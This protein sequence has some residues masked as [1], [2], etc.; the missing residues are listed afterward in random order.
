[1]KKILLILI[2]GWNML[3]AASIT[4]AQP[5]E[6][7]VPRP[8]LDLSQIKTL[9]QQARSLME[10]YKDRR[11]RYLT[12]RE[13]LK[14]RYTLSTTPDQRDKIK[15]EMMNL[16]AVM[17]TYAVTVV[18]S[19]RG[20]AQGMLAEV[21]TTIGVMDQLEDQFARAQE[22]VD[23]RAKVY[24]RKVERAKRLLKDIGER[25]GRTTDPE[26]KQ[27][28]LRNS[29]LL[30][31]R[32]A[33]VSMLAEH[34]P[35]LKGDTM[36]GLNDQ[37]IGWRGALEEYES[38]LVAYEADLHAARD[39]LMGLAEAKRL[40]VEVEAIRQ[41]LVD[42]DIRKMAFD[43][44]ELIREISSPM[45]GEEGTRP[46]DLWNRRTMTEE[47]LRKISEDE[48]YLD[49]LIRQLTHPDDN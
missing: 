31:R 15:A 45:V 5:K 40:E 26:M 33:D 25:F 17:L 22:G 14:G 41:K 34:L 44:F 43:P 29:E 2:L 28:L 36:E 37:L 1:M 24:Q 16:D 3:L 32:I 27:M 21:G 8:K 38:Y 18:D 30:L 47:D 42:A 19:M 39:Y 4:A 46:V 35:K 11:N 48:K 12:R 6:R 7:T 20:V 13:R 23:E 49:N 9:S 10:D